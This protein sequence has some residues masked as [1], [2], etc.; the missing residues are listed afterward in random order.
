MALPTPKGKQA[1]VLGL[2]PTGH[3]V[4]LGTAGSGKTTLAIL[5]AAFLADPSTDHFGPTLLVTFN[6]TLVTY[7]RRQHLRWA[8]NA[9]AIVKI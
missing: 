8:L 4:V 6:R 1:D 3:V 2:R 9:M 7:L 5:R